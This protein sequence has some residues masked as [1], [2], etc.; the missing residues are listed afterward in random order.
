MTYH[1]WVVGWV[2]YFDTINKPTVSSS[3][4]SGT[5]MTHCNTSSCEEKILRKFFFNS[6][7]AVS[8]KECWNP[9]VNSQAVI[10]A[11]SKC[12]QYKNLHCFGLPGTSNNFKLLVTENSSSVHI[13]L[14]FLMV[15]VTILCRPEWNMYTTWQ[16]NK[17]VQEGPLKRKLLF[18]QWNPVMVHWNWNFLWAPHQEMCLNTL[19][20]HRTSTAFVVVVVRLCQQIKH[21]VHTVY[22]DWWLFG[23]K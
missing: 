6:D 23:L 17:K 14:F 2:G 18:V 22:M 9:H 13:L 16:V 4:L 12:K 3:L 19:N 21:K 1:L 11:V 8:I 7:C 20:W 15:D 5:V 10:N